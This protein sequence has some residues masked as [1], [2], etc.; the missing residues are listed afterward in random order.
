MVKVRF[1]AVRIM[2]MARLGAL[3]AAWSCSSNDY[4]TS[5]NHVVVNGTMTASIDSYG[6]WNASHLATATAANGALTIEGEDAS[7]T[8]VT[9]FLIGIDLNTTQPDLRREINLLPSN[10]DTVGYVQFFEHQGNQYTTLSG[11][12]ATV[13][14]THVS[15]DSVVGI[16]GFITS[17]PPGSPFL[18]AFWSAE[19]GVFN[20]KP[21]VGKP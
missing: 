1:P 19:N 8:H 12:H 17:L 6:L 11:G 21:T 5:T 18:P 3:A 13:V 4:P 9:L 7:L 16:F 14:L 20:I 15:P 10:A 2:R